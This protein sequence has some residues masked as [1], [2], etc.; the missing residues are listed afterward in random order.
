MTRYDGL[1]FGLRTEEMS[2]TEELF[3]SVRHKGFNE[4]VR[5]RI[6]A[7][8]YF[9]LKENYDNYFIKAL[10]VRRLISKDF[11]EVFR[12]VDLLLTPVALSD[13]PSF[14]DF[15]SSDNRTQTAKHDYCTQPVNLAGLPAATLP[16]KLSKRSL[17]LSLQII[18]DR[19]QEQKVLQASKWLENRLNF[20]LPE[21]ISDL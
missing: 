10:Q 8:N 7:G 14:K 21:L 19:C 20:H 4:V 18:G 5:G 6:L 3:A 16:V 1:E 11:E 2:S 13:A 17:P 12:K 9:L 15:S